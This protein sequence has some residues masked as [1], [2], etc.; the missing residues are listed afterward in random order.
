MDY[1]AIFKNCL[2][3]IRTEEGYFPIRFTESQLEGYRAAGDLPEV[4]SLCASGVIMEFVTDIPKLSFSYQVIRPYKPNAVFDIYENDSLCQVV[5]IPDSSTSGRVVYKRQNSEKSKITIYLP[6][7]TPLTIDEIKIGNYSLADA[8]KK[9]ILFLG[10]SITQGMTSISPSLTYTSLLGRFYHAEILNQAIAGECF[11]E[12]YLEKNLG[13]SPDSV[14]VAFGTNDV[15]N[16][17]SIVEIQ[18]NIRAYLKKL[19]HIYGNCQIYA[20]T[21]IWRD[22]ADQPLFWDKIKVVRQIIEEEAH[23]T[24]I[25]TVDGLLLVPHLSNYFYDGTTH[26][27]ENG[28]HLY[29]LNLCSQING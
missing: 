10:D 29:A 25:Q 23:K 8:A 7:L 14:F 6:H 1:S 4:R 12:K 24:E 17:E 21:P 2:R 13:F 20:I 18:Q 26:P 11:Q 27:N 22:F 19:A 15:T 5:G 3:V 16:I 9:K 28:F